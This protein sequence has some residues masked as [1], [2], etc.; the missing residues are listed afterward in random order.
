MNLQ[1]ITLAAC[2]FLT[3]VQFEDTP[4]IEYHQAASEHQYACTTDTECRDEYH[5]MT[6]EWPADMGGPESAQT[7]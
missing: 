6:G 7:E 5:R 4:A 3:G 1:P 2:M